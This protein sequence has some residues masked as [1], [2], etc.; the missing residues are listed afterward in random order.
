ME[1][2]LCLLTTQ[3]VL[4]VILLNKGSQSRHGHDFAGHE[5]PQEG[6]RWLS[7]QPFEAEENRNTAI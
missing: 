5:E 7:H 6:P 4:F 2:I 1:D 3:V